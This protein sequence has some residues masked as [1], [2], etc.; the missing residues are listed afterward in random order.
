MDTGAQNAEQ[1]L[2][3]LEF[4]AFLWA[5]GLGRR[6]RGAHCKAHLAHPIGLITF[7]EPYGLAPGKSCPTGVPE[8][9]EGSIEIA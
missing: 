1:G 8:T 3:K 5:L 2:K 6:W 9:G 7:R 4:S